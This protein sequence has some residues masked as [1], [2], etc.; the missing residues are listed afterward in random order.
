MIP[1]TSVNVKPTN[2]LVDVTWSD[3]E[4]RGLLKC[5]SVQVK[6]NTGQLICVCYNALLMSTQILMKSYQLSV[7]LSP[8]HPLQKTNDSWLN[9]N[10][11]RVIYF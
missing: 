5:L 7:I 4:K 10:Y 3:G 6:S 9:V 8:P 2:Y 11:Y 1:S